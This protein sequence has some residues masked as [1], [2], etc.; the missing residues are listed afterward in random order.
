MNQHENRTV[1]SLTAEQRARLAALRQGGS[2]SV[3]PRGTA[4]PRTGRTEAPLSPGQQ[5]IWFLN[6]F[7]PDESVYNI[8]G[9]YRLTGRLSVGGLQRAVDALVQRHPSLR[10]RFTVVNELPVQ[11]VDPDTRITV[12]VR[13]V[14]PEKLAA[15][16]T[17]FSRRPFD[18]ESGPL[19]R[20][21]VA[22]T[23][24]TESVLSIV[25]HHIV[26]DGWSLGV[27]IREFVALYSAFVNGSSVTLAEPAIS[28]VDYSLWLRGPERSR[29]NAEHLRYWTE[30]LA[31]SP[32]LIDLPTDEPRPPVQS[33]NGARVSFS[34]PGPLRRRVEELARS[35]GA[36]PYM[37]LLTA[38]YAL[39]HRW[40]GQSQLACATPV[41]NR[42]T[43]ETEALIGFFVNTVV[44][45]ADLSGSP[46]FQALLDQVRDTCVGSLDHQELPFEQLVD[47]LKLGR[48]PSHNP[49]AQVMFILQSAPSTVMELPGLLLEPIPMDTGTSKFDLSLELTPTDQG[50]D[51]VVEYASDLFDETT[52]QRFARHYVRLLE[53]MVDAPATEVLSAPMLTEAERDHLSTWNATEADTAYESCVPDWIARQVAAR[54]EDVALVAADGTQFTYR[55]LA[56]R[57]G[58]VANLLR[59]CGV[60]PDTRVGLC[61]SRGP[62]LVF[63]L[64]G[65]LVAGGAYVPFDPSQPAERIA[66]MVREGGVDIVLTTADCVSAL[67][68]IPE[69]VN[70][71]RLD[72]ASVRDLLSEQEETWPAARPAPSHL[73]YVIYTSGSTG[74][75]KGV[76]VEHRSVVNRINWMQAQYGLRPS[77]RVMQKTVHTFDVSVWEFLWPLMHGAAIVLASP[78]AHREP[79]TL[80][81]EIRRQQVTHIHFV[82]TALSAL[83]T[84]GSLGDTSV[85]RI[86][87]SGDVLP[88]ELC[89]RVYA[90]CS[91]AV[92]NLYGPTECAIDVTY[93]SWHPQASGQPP[94][95]RP[96]ANTR[97]HVVDAAGH[98]LPVGV[99]GEL[100]VGGVQVARGYLNR[101][102]LTEERFLPDPFSVVAGDRIY[103]TG[104]LV[105]RRPDGDLEFLGRIDNQVKVRGFRIELGEVEAALREAPGVLDAAVVCRTDPAGDKQLL[106][107]LVADAERLASDPGDDGERVGEWSAVFDQA[108]DDGDGPEPQE[109]GLNLKGWVSSYT[110][111]PI[112][113]DD[114]VEW[115]DAAVDRITASKPRTV[116][117]I[118]CGTGL[119]ALRLAADCDRYIGVDI[120][121]KGL[122]YIAEEA[123]RLG[124][125]DR[126]EL[127]RLPAHDLDALKGLTF[128][129]VVINSVIQYFPDRAY[130]DAVLRQAVA[131]LAPGGKV[132]VGDVRPLA[133]AETLHY[134]VARFGAPDTARERLLDRAARRAAEETELL[135]D[136]AYF[137]GLLGR[138]P[139]VDRVETALKRGL[140]ANELNDF[141][142]DVIIERGGTAG[143]PVASYTDWDAEI[144][145]VARLEKRLAELGED[146]LAV[147][148]IPNARLQNHLPNPAS[149]QAV[150]PEQ[151]WELAQTHGLDLQLTWS[152]GNATAGRMAAVFHRRNV[153]P[154]IAHTP[155]GE[156]TNDPA[157]GVALRALPHLL[158]GRLRERLPD[159]MVPGSIVVLPE[160]PTTSSGKVDRKALV[161]IAEERYVGLQSTAPRTATE[162]LVA[163]VWRD[164]LNLPVVTA[165]DNFFDLGGDSIKSTQ[166]AARLRDAGRPVLI[167]S[168][169]SH[170]TVERLAEFLD[171]QA[172]GDTAGPD[173]ASP[174]TSGS[175]ASDHRYP[176]SPLQE[177]MLRLLPERGDDGLYVVQRILRYEGEISPEAADQAWA[178]TVQETPFLRTVLREAGGEV[179]QVADVPAEDL[180]T[181]VTFL[182]W[183]SRGAAEQIGLLDA[184]LRTDRAAGFDAA[185]A[186][187][188]R[189]AFIRIDNRRGV[190]V[191]TMDYRRLDGWSFPLYL[192]R[193]LTRYADAA[194][195]TPAPSFDYADYLAWRAKR[196]R[197]GSVCAWWRE[198][199]QGFDRLPA[200]PLRGRTSD[201]F[202]VAQ[203]RFGPKD[204]RRFGAACRR[205]R[206]TQAAALQ[207]LWGA[208]LQH[209]DG[210]DAPQFGVT[211]SGRSPEVRGIEHAMGMFMNTLPVRWQASLEDPLQLWLDRASSAVLDLIEHDMIGMPELEELAG[212]DEHTTLFDTYVVYQNTPSVSTDET[213]PSG[214]S[215]VDESPIAVAQQEHR[216]RVD[217]Y[218][219]ADGYLDV[220]LSGYEPE[221]RLHAYLTTLRDLF[222]NASDAEGT[223]RMAELLAAPEARD[224]PRV[225]TLRDCLQALAHDTPIPHRAEETR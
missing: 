122:D 214:F 89:E 183:S 195:N 113:R 100:W 94:I 117:E 104:D 3:A 178:A 153:R 78:D 192:E 41:A 123:E 162:R 204:V 60:G 138:I 143:E 106:A 149:G 31:D 96:V 97:T 29:R 210:R 92:D 114:M 17:D 58:R 86:F 124:L 127:R 14:S 172:V 119:F 129:S 108:Y 130:L 141:R 220:L 53:A 66:R 158:R 205:A 11:Q 48:E 177:H 154:Y 43:V 168:I 136:P 102:D 151:L 5:R 190:W 152:P 49:L 156:V 110:S 155:R 217:I 198:R 21:L 105:R 54:G 25:I 222:V 194:G 107:Y 164:V 7:L 76:M 184:F 157:R 12:A 74:T 115:L 167:R 187:P 176:L 79:A 35:R 8:A 120:A 65:T 42:A 160:L 1:T 59:V 225:V 109:A 24:E 75:P 166:V 213:A 38:Y 180:P 67:A 181:A 215:L 140:G 95:G 161:D 16:L 150:H 36:T 191:L 44:L 134:S 101:P 118:G 46:T 64:V 163:E 207:A 23:G 10:T 112:P 55:E 144:D 196:L 125:T 174:N 211:T 170:Q 70:V 47:E 68:D 50:F 182:D 133:L 142:Y 173:A 223:V 56:A 85:R 199:V 91:V 147:D 51:A 175:A 221:Y 72:E 26:A 132:F 116:L 33:F 208:T 45:S 216:L 61:L 169:F 202:E 145:G 77:D 63:A 18:L 197:D 82:P 93:W 19:L 188:T 121:Q 84:H 39:L 88:A 57:G 98:E 219:N 87:C 218:P 212:T 111:R 165:Q 206:T 200:G 128:D 131:L 137:T 148:G 171:A 71:L 52:V 224:A 139:G 90:D 135:V 81:D 103:R 126:V 32:R 28:Y 159:Y 193:F 37:A 22:R 209:V 73:A 6:R 83:L 40:S 2:R 15:E 9:S 80:L 13:D 186:L 99:A 20:M 27:F 30:R 203:I 179:T 62:E 4:I 34:I 189:F 69:G 185:R 146:W 201:A